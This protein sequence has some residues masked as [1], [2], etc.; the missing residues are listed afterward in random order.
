[1]E[2]VATGTVAVD[3]QPLSIAT[4][5]GSVWV[6][7]GGANLLDRI[8]PA[9]MVVSHR[10][11]IDGAISVAVGFGS[12]WIGSG[13][14][15]LARL[16]PATNRVIATIPTGSQAQSVAIAAGSVWTTDYLAATVLRIDPATNAITARIG[17]GQYPLLLAASDDQVWVANIQSV[18]RIDPV[19]NEVVAKSHDLGP[20]T[21]DTLGLAYGFGALWATRGQGVLDQIDPGS[22][23]VVSQIPVGMQPIGVAAGAGA[24]WVASAG[25]ARVASAA[26]HVA[27]DAAVDRM[28]V[29]LGAVVAEVKVVGSPYAIATDNNDVWVAS[30][31]GNAVTRIAAQQ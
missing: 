3:E 6:A 18:Y 4:G 20:P 29:T 13:Q 11:A 15:F 9:A 5:M 21:D 25:N 30:D 22:L 16:D 14:G 7:C 10:V 12:A 8:D 27:P 2:N 26:T 23:A 1:L 28:D 31:R 19:R 24:V 17:V